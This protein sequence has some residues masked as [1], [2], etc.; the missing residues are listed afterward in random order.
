MK[1]DQNEL[2]RALKRH[3]EIVALS[4]L[5]QGARPCNRKCGSLATR[6]NAYDGPL[7]D[8]CAEFSL[9]YC[10]EHRDDMP[11]L[12]DEQLEFRDIDPAARYIR[13][14]IALLKG[15]EAPRR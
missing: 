13:R 15:E 9:R 2:T 7:C 3:G 12:R 11:F 6:E 1:N 8:S 5:L 14:L 10:N 4:T